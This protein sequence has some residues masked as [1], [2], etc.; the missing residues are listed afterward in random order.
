MRE[1]EGGGGGG[2]GGEN[3]MSVCVSLSLCCCY[4]LSPE[5]KSC[6]C[7]LIWN[8]TETKK[9]PRLLSCLFRRKCSGL[10]QDQTESLPVLV[11][12]MQQSGR[13]ASLDMLKEL[14]PSQNGFCSIKLKA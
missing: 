4:T 6:Q 12:V 8:E 1:R 10:F 7:L 11:R 5:F 3:L 13:L 14:Q 9:A 2:E